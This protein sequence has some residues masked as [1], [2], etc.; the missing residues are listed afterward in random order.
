MTMW[1]DEWYLRRS[2]TTSESGDARVLVVV[3]PS[4]EDWHRI[5]SQGWYRIPLRRAPRRI[6]A[7][8]L[9]FYHTQASGPLRWSIRFYAPVLGY[10]LATRRELIPEETDHPRADERYYR[11]ALGSLQALPHSIP[12]RHL[13]RVTFILTTL[14]QLLR[15]EE[16]NDLWQRESTQ[17][18]LERALGLAELCTS[19]GSVAL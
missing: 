17:E 13:R 4:L 14:A 3:V 12:S 11:I 16:I 19:Y 10:S 18:G 9:A 2:T 5:S 8:Y 1:D 15:A 7:E 6:G